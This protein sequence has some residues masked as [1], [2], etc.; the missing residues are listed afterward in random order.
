MVIVLEIL[1]VIAL[2]SA[3]LYSVIILLCGYGWY[4]IGSKTLSA[5]KRATIVSVI[6]AARNESENIMQ[7]LTTLVSQNYPKQKFEIILIDD[8][9]TDDT[10]SKAHKF[11]IQHPHLVRVII[12]TLTLHHHGKKAAIT[13]GVCL[14]NGELI[15]TTDA[16]CTMGQD[17]IASIVDFFEFSSA[18]MIV[19]P[20]CFHNERSFFNKMQQL[21]FLALMATTGGSLYFN[22]AI[23]CN[24]ANLAYT[25]NVFLEQK[26]FEGASNSASGDDVL[27]MY[28]IKK[29]YPKEVLFL[30]NKKV[31][32][33]TEAKRTLSAFM[34]QRKRWAS[35]KFIEF[36]SDTKTV[37]L[38][39]YFFNLFLF[40]IAV[41]SIFQSQLSIFSI[42]LITFLITLFL[43]KSFVDFLLL[44]LSASFFNGKN[45]LIF[46]LPEQVLYIIYV[47][48]SGV[49]ALGRKYEW[50]GRIINEKEKG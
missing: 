17:W 8:H 25:K 15:I 1:V 23:M 18:K 9:S 19:A 30:K 6:V 36:N 35:K 31:I 43:I 37:S 42:P 47:V 45:L 39:V 10:L 26:G 13:Q 33:Y 27:L 21:E 20:V 24:G 50:K 3:V 32:V 48:I 41:T 46:F 11:C 7:I 44:F 5:G 29:A 4:K 28:K 12:Q 2:L 16:D 49:A 38:I 40:L 34:N 14:A 22:K